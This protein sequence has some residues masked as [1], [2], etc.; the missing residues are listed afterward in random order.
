MFVVTVDTKE[1]F[2]NFGHQRALRIQWRSFWHSIGYE[3]MGDLC[4][5]ATCSMQLTGQNLHVMSMRNM[6]EDTNFKGSDLSDPFVYIYSM[7][8]G[9]LSPTMQIFPSLLQTMNF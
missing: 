3:Q 8:L 9:W 7:P 2:I 4:R 1:Y 6:L 5:S